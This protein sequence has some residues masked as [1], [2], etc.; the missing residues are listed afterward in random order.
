M[1]P[2]RIQCHYL[3]D[4]SENSDVHGLDRSNGEGF[5]LP[6]HGNEAVEVEEEVGN[7]DYVVETFEDDLDDFHILFAESDDD[8]DESSDLKSPEV[9]VIFCTLC[10]STLSSRGMRCFLLTDTSKQ[11]FSTD[12]PKL[13]AVEELG[14]SYKIET[15]NCMIRNTFC[16]Q[17]SAKIGYHVVEP[18]NFC[19]NADNN[20]HYWLLNQNVEHVALMLEKRRMTAEGDG[21]IVS[22]FALTWDQ[23][24]YNGRDV[25][26]PRLFLSEEAREAQEEDMVCCICSEIMHYPVYL[27]CGGDGSSHQVSSLQDAS[28]PPPPP[29]TTRTRKEATE[30]SVPSTKGKHRLCFGCAWR[31]VDARK[32]C[33]FDRLS[34]S[35]TDIHRDVQMQERINSLIVHCR[36]GCELLPG[37]NCCY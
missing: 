24:P 34:I 37:L 3:E 21:G 35:H 8:E 28:T 9:L 2:D 31:E 11:L 14:E 36:F 12:I 13:E 4:D 27:T 19:Q 18:C 7:E 26:V 30:A 20:G 1:D 17:C 22:Q 5:Q 23:L 16:K 33:P 10:N 25:T 6:Q 32:C 29:T 15:C